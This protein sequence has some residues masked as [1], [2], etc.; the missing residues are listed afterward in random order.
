MP[1]SS[2]RKQLNK[3]KSTKGAILAEMLIQTLKPVTLVRAQ[4]F[5]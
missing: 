4:E 3:W 2:I 1:Y 5:I